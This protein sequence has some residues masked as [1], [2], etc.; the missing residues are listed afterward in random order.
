MR[1]RGGGVLLLLLRG[2]LVRGGCIAACR[3]AA[4]IGRRLLRL[5]RGDAVG[6][7]VGPAV[8]RSRGLMPV[9]RPVRLLLSW[10]VLAVR[11]LCRGVV[12]RGWRGSVLLVGRR[13][14]RRLRHEALRQLV[15]DHRAAQQHRHDAG[16]LHDLPRVARD[17]EHLVGRGRSRCSHVQRKHDEPCAGVH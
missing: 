5:R 13:G 3:G 14:G 7:V 9:R 16:G 6:G 1:R 10:R 11:R 17:L 8:L 15:A 4:P 12:L 2:L